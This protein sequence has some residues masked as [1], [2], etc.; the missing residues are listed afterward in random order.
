MET[1]QLYAVAFV[2]KL[3][4]PLFLFSQEE[5]AESLNLQ[6]IMFGALDYVEAKR[7]R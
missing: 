1:R 4:Q 2:G 7:K 3:D 6:M 5:A